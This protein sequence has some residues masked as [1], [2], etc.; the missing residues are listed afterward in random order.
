MAHMA[1]GGQHT[2]LRAKLRAKIN[3][4]LSALPCAALPTCGRLALCFFDAW[5]CG[6]EF[7]SQSDPNFSLPPVPKSPTPL[8]GEYS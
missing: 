8:S 1:S 5:I 4:L 7:R 3:A 6:L 2:A